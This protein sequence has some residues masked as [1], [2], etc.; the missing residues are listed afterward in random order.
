MIS[1]I[2]S[3][4]FMFCSYYSSSYAFYVLLNEPDY[5]MKMISVISIIASIHNINV[6]KK[7]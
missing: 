3:S 7:I 2:L 4:S 6:M 1:S 5:S